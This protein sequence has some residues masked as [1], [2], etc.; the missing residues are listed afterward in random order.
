MFRIPTRV[1]L[2]PGSVQKLP[3]VLAGLEAK[4][5]LVLTDRGVRSALWFDDVLA[6]CGSHDLDDSIE[7]NPKHHSIDILGEQARAGSYD[8]VIGIGGGSVLDA[9]KAVSML[10]A[11]LGPVASFEGKN[12]F[13]NPAIPFIAIPTTCGT[14]SEVTW[15][16]VISVPEEKRKISVKGDGMFPAFALV[17]SNLIESLPPHLIASTGMDAFT[18]AIEAI[19]GKPANPTSDVLAL[20]A[21]QLLWIYLIDA[22]SE[23]EATEAKEYVMRAS[24]LAGMAFGNA[25]VGAVH[26]LSESIGGVLDLPHGLLNTLLLAPTLTYQ[27]D[28]IQEPL[29]R[30]AS[31]VGVELEVFVYALTER[32]R[33]LPLSDWN[34]LNIKPELFDELARLAEGNGSNPSNRMN[35]TARDYKAIL[36][37][38]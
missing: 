4:H 3:Q 36:E 27:Q 33:Q 28:S 12:R 9:A 10:A 2:H 17:D 32:I 19:I 16:S 37:S 13:P 35:M 20:E 22:C 34:S 14:G 8:A 21:I 7:P 31:A 23:T 11:N 5:V 30:I 26:C 25:D 38:L 24:T 29:G 15:V 6:L 18:H 1:A